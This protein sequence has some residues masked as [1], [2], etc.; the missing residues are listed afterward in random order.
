MVE[1][2]RASVER[3]PG[4]N[5]LG[6]DTTNPK[7]KKGLANPSAPSEYGAAWL[8]LQCR[9]IPAVR[10]AV[11]V[12]REGDA[13]SVLSGWPTNEIGDATPLSELAER[14]LFE[15]R[16]LTAD[17]IG[18]TGANRT[19][20][21]LAT[22]VGI[23]DAQMAAVA[24]VLAAEESTKL[25]LD[26]NAVAEELKWGAGWLEVLAW[27]EQTKQAKADRDRIAKCLDVLAVCADQATLPGTAMAIANELA[28]QFVCDR[29]SVGRAFPGGSLRLLAM[30]HSATFK[31]N[32]RVV[33]AIE[34]AMEEASEQACTVCHPPPS[35]QERISTFAQE[36]LARLSDGTAP[37]VL[38][39][40]VF[41]PNG[42]V[43]GAIT[44]ERHRGP[45]F[46]K[47]EIDAAD[48]VASLFAPLLTALLRS[49]RLV[50]GRAIDAAEAMIGS[51][52]GPRRLALK[53]VVI[54]AAVGTAALA[55]ATGEHR[56]TAR[57]VLEPQVQRAIT[58]PFDTFIVNA[59]ARAGDIVKQGQLLAV[60]E[61]RDFVVELAKWQAERDKLVQRQREALA[62]SDRSALAVLGHQIE[63]ALAQLAFVEDRLARTRITAPFDGTIVSGDLSQM[64][65]SP[66]E[67]GKSLFEIAPLD[68]YRISMQIDE[69]DIAFV[70]TGQSGV[71]TL[72]GMSGTSLPLVV[73]SITPVTTPREG[74]N[75][76][77]AEAVLEHSATQLRP[78][79]EGIAKLDAGSRPL[80][81]IWLHPLIDWWRLMAW[82]YLP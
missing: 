54:L 67:K 75:T 35:R 10:R 40:V 25:H 36:E 14:A 43:A 20:V 2:K 19:E 1:V 5:P 59:P 34:S 48:A 61:S 22:P 77:K 56:V 70:R 46:D 13:A 50:A 66:M 49:N 27:V 41:N 55:L 26:L 12:I 57:A 51:A 72:A 63:Q 16:I 23:A 4:W 18:L 9:R 81:W 47:T 11:L 15:A 30:S 80:L 52:L 44:L 76:F 17:A 64:L 39:V 60:L 65:G 62:K 24:I 3:P 29:V 37:S 68:A 7:A 8:A 73:T 21:L 74:R 28:A 78:G 69:R 71:V 33:A 82:K 6:S 31:A 45:N 53:L 79:L 42:R 58:A 32:T 38:S